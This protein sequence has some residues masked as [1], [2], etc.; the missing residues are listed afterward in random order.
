MRSG[1]RYHAAAAPPNGMML[2][3]LNPEL[4]T[5]LSVK[6]QLSIRNRIQ[7]RDRDAAAG[8]L[9]SCHGSLDEAVGLYFAE[10][11]EE[12]VRTERLYEDVRAARSTDPPVAVTDITSPAEEDQ[13]PAYVVEDAASGY[14]EP[15][16]SVRVRVR[17][18]RVVDKVFGAKWLVAELF[19]SVGAEGGRRTG[20]RPFRL[21]R[22]AGAE[23]EEVLRRD[24]TFEELGL[25]RWTLHLLFGRTRLPEESCGQ[26]R[27]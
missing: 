7:Q 19:R 5:R 8:H 22:F 6:C 10:A 14:G 1:R 9:A 27:A 3:K 24:A 25:H 17:D 15:A 4:P 23:S 21:V 13:Y 18:G 11:E 12:P 26:S 16:C 20:G 2:S